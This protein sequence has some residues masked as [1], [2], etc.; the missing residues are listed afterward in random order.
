M[1]VGT[2][3]EHPRAIPLHHE[4]H[5]VGELAALASSH[6]V[7]ASPELAAAMGQYGD[8]MLVAGG[9]PLEFFGPGMDDL[10]GGFGRRGEAPGVAD[11]GKAG[12][13]VDFAESGHL[14][15]WWWRVDRVG[16]AGFGA[17]GEV[18]DGG[19]RKKAS[20]NGIKFG[21]LCATSYRAEV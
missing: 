21:I 11:D 4:D 7:A 6:P 20:W 10:V 14:C 15:R 2:L 17:A 5:G 12:D 18:C 13:V 19:N 8:D 9:R 1:A 3:A 16:G